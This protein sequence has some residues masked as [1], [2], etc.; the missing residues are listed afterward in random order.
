MR[1]KRKKRKSAASSIVSD[2]ADM[3]SK[4][5]WWGALLVG[6]GAFLVLYHIVPWW[7]ESRLSARSESP[8]Y[9]ALEIVFSLRARLFEWL[10]V[11]CGLLGVYFSVRNIFFGIKVSKR[12]K[13]CCHCL[14]SHRS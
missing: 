1:P 12:E 7:M 13:T 8:M 6:I 14:Q 2:T 9:G 5:P 3:A 4:L 11:A 10:G